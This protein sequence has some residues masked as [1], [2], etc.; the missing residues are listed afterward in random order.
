MRESA[1]MIL[2]YTDV[3]LYFC[4]LPIFVTPMM[5]ELCEK[6]RKMREDLFV[7]R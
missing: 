3:D 2:I 4:R 7:L 5:R 1:L 6:E